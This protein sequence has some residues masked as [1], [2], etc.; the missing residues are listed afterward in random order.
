MDSTTLGRSIQEDPLV[1]VDF[2]PSNV[3]NVFTE[4]VKIFR[5][6]TRRL[7]RL[8]ETFS[9]FVTAETFDELHQEVIRIDAQSTA[10]LEEVRRSSTKNYE[11]LKNALNSVRDT[12]DAEH[13]NV[14]GEARRLVTAELRAY[15]TPDEIIQPVGGPIAE[16]QKKVVQ[17][18]DA[19]DDLALPRVEPAPAQG[20]DVASSYRVADLESRVD[21]VEARLTSYPQ[22]ESDLQSL[23][24]QL[25]VATRRLDKRLNDVLETLRQKFQAANREAVELT[26]PIPIV[27]KPPP[28]QVSKQPSP[29]PEKVVSTATV[30]IESSAVRAEP[31]LVIAPVATIARLSP[32]NLRSANPEDTSTPTVIYKTE[33]NSSLRVVNE[34]EWAKEHDYKAGGCNAP[35]TAGFPNLGRNG[36]HRERKPRA[37]VD[38]PEPAHCPDCP[39]TAE[40]APGRGGTEADCPRPA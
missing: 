32:E 37:N 40:G 15:P 22:I 11:E 30:K 5:D 18:A 19:I 33:L 12:C 29:V 13:L 7:V 8:E 39:A 35:G 6:Q 23:L 38:H 17:M 14:L 2:D 27:T 28:L 31:G 34:L 1:T 21:G 25:P 36:R 16:L 24:V 3:S 10:S 9:H 4:I 26:A 20:R